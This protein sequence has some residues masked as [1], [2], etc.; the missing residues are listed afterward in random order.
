[1]DIQ[2][3]SGSLSEKWIHF[4]IDTKYKFLSAHYS[5]N[6]YISNGHGKVWNVPETRY[7]WKYIVM[8]IDMFHIHSMYT[9]IHH[10]LNIKLWFDSY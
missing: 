9:L 8:I 1:M 7:R 6:K 3:V 5:P 10:P 4:I 2:I